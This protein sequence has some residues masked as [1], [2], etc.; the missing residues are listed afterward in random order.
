[1]ALTSGRWSSA[2]SSSAPLVQACPSRTPSSTST[3]TGIRTRSWLHMAQTSPSG[4]PTCPWTA[5]ALVGSRATTT[6]ATA[7][8]MASPLFGCRPCPAPRAAGTELAPRTWAARAGEVAR[9]GIQAWRRRMPWLLAASPRWRGWGRTASSWRPAAPPATRRAPASRAPT[10]LRAVA[11]T[12]PHA[13]TATC[14][15]TAKSPSGSDLPSRRA[16]GCATGC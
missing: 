2:A 6:T 15:T 12:G 8:R 5:A 13:A 14:R 10:G 9:C 7:K 11:P 4:C 3:S 1:M 16:R